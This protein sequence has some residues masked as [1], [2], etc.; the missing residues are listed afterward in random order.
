MFSIARTGAGSRKIIARLMKLLIGRD[1]LVEEEES[2]YL[3]DSGADS[4]DARAL[5][6][7]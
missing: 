1:V 4:D 6:P 7:L 3:A 2:S 5:R